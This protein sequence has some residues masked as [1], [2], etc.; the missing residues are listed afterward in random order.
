MI[1]AVCMKADTTNIVEVK[2]NGNW[3]MEQV[4]FRQLKL[5]KHAKLQ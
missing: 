4:M 1:I 3:R 2:P 5:R